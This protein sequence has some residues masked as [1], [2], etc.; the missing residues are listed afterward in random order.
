LVTIRLDF[1]HFSLKGHELVD[2]SSSTWIT[3]QCCGDR[4]LRSFQDVIALTGRR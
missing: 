1:M 2:G 3:A 4:P